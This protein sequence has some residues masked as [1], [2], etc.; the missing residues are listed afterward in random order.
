MKPKNFILDA[1]AVA[2]VGIGLWWFTRPTVTAP[3]KPPQAPMLAKADSAPKIVAPQSIAPPI[4]P[5]AT[6]TQAENRAVAAT[7]PHPQTP[8][9]APDADSP[10]KVEPQV[11]LNDAISQAIRV[12]QAKDFSGMVKLLPQSF[13]DLMIQDGAIE[14][15]EDYAKKL[16]E[17]PQ[18]D[19][20]INRVLQVLQ[21]LQNQAPEMSPDDTIATYK[22]D[23][24]INQADT[25][26]FRKEN[27]FWYLPYIPVYLPVKGITQ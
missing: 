8:N 22:I 7:T 11:D 13:I 15:S 16:R 9:A 2:I 17:I 20:N 23:P 25:V 4:V 24:P 21:S 14:S 6:I 1:V 27:G 12:Y 18:E 19:E 26:Y 10:L 3:E 5:P